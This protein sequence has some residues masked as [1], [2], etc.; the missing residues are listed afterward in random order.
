M[1]SCDAIVIGGG[2]NGLACAFRLQQ[3]GRRVMVVEAADKPGGA[4]SARGVLG[5]GTA[6]AMAHLVNKFDPRVEAGMRLADHGLTWLT[7]ALATTAVSATGRHLVLQGTAG[8]ILSGDVSPQDRAA[9]SSLR[10]DVMRYAQLLAPFNAMTPPSLAKG[11]GNEWLKLA[12]IGLGLRTMNRAKLREL[13]RLL[14]INVYD[15]L[16]DEIADPL[17]KGTL[18]FDATLGSWLGPRSPNSFI[19]LLQRLAGEAGGRRG[20][21]ALPA[22]GMARLAGAMAASATAE[23]V[24]IRYNA[25]VTRIII[26]NDAA[27]GVLLGNGDELRAPL[28]V[29]AA[30]PKTTLLSMVG[31]RQLDTGLFTRM[32]HQKSRGA[33]AKLHL[34]LDDLPDFRGADPK[35]RLVI[36]PSPQAVENAF[37]PVKY[38]EVPEE[39]VMEIVIPSAFEPGH[40]PARQHLLSAI[41]QYAPHA[42]VAGRDAA[43]SSLLRN[44]LA[45]LESHAPGIGSRILK[46]EMLMPYDIEETYGLV[47]GNWHHGELSVEQML[48]LRPLPELARYATPIR[49]L[50]LAS[51]GSHPGGGISGSAGWNAAEA[52]SRGTA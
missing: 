48:F 28:V 1:P 8:E 49:G 4:A 37:N 45:V 27:V 52:I 39:P 31:H 30:S 7:T 21:L 12:R 11:K 2:V 26:E 22:G 50:W 13:M 18:A 15:V 40:A 16:E 47:G 24:I 10:E 44:S 23:G 17:L 19:L 20:A 25:R 36:A 35:T 38:G 33:A 43:R 46:S 41:V 9:W 34:L 32:R 6:S 3:A 5:P 51:A 42:P 14:L 29:S